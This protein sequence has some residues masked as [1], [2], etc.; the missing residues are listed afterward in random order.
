MKS[1]KLVIYYSFDGNTAFIADQIVKRLQAD[2]LALRPDKE[3]KTHGFLKYFWGGKMVYMKESP[4]LEGFTVIPQNYDVIFIG[5]PVWS[6]TFAPPL[7]S[8]FAKDLF[9]QKKIV[10]FCCNG[11]NKG[12]TFEDMRNNLKDN[13]IISEMDFYEPLRNQE[14]N[15]EKINSWLDQVEKLLLI[16]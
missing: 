7:R 3:P 11:G 8:L 14:S 4:N 13:N 15:V 6:W 9:H 5:T 2:I 16:S 1:K 10:L 12:K